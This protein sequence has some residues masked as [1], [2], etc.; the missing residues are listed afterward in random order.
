MEVKLKSCADC[1][2]GE[3]A[4]IIDVPPHRLISKI[5]TARKKPD[6][7]FIIGYVG[8]GNAGNK[9]AAEFFT[10]P[11]NRQPQNGNRQRPKQYPK[12][13]CEKN[14]TGEK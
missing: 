6:R 14:M 2:V 1:V 4:K 3:A 10:G 5:A 9:R 13:T 11:V 8:I 12:K 7:L